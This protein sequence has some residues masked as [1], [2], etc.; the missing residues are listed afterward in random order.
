MPYTGCGP[1]GEEFGHGDAAGFG[2]TAE[3]VADQVDDHDVLGDILDGRTQ[4]VGVAVQ[5]KGALMGLE[6]SR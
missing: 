2:H 3:V 5:W 6:A 1:D 4:L